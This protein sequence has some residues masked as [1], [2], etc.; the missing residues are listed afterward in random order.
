MISASMRGKAYLHERSNIIDAFS[1]VNI[2]RKG[3][4]RM[5]GAV[6]IRNAE[7]SEPLA[8]R[9][10]IEFVNRQKRFPKSESDS[11]HFVTDFVMGHQ[12]LLCI[13]TGKVSSAICSSDVM[14]QLT[15]DFIWELE[16]LYYKHNINFNSLVV[17]FN[18]TVNVSGLRSNCSQVG[19]GTMLEETSLYLR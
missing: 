6:C 19:D 14:E 1:S 3:R 7:R 15:E 18:E 11:G 5:S 13:R 8:I 4:R 12:N 16:L 10:L 9:D 2:I 17:F